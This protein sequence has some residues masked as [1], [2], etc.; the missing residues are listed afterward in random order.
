MTH[1]IFR[2]MMED[3]PLEDNVQVEKEPRRE[4][5]PTEERP[6]VKTPDVSPERIR[7]MKRAFKPTWLHEQIDSEAKNPGSNGKKG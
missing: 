5:A 4:L 6:E 3:S 1:L 2:N 7:R